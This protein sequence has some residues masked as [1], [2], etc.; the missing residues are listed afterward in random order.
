MAIRMN[1]VTYEDNEEGHKQLV[2]DFLETGAVE[3]RISA[4]VLTEA[5]EVAP[6]L[7]LKVIQ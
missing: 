4:D 3:V 2:A 6:Q 1:G 5:I 7:P